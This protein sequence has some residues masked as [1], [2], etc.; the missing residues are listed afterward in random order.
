MR[1]QQFQGPEAQALSFAREH[2][3]STF[4]NRLTLGLRGSTLARPQLVLKPRHDR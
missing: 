3:L 4:P 2:P 1:K